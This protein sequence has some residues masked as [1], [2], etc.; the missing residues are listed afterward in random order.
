M[1]HLRIHLTHLRGRRATTSIITAMVAGPN[2]TAW[3]TMCDALGIGAD[4][5]VG[6][7]FVSVEGNGEQVAAS[8]HLYSYDDAVAAAGPRWKDWLTDRFTPLV[9]PLGT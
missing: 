8:I 3:T 6:T 2:D 9:D 4:L 7:A 5:V 1:A